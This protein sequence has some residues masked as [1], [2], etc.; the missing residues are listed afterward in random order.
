MNS[1]YNIFLIKYTIKNVLFDVNIEI[2]E[3]HKNLE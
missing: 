3:L 1:M 2:L